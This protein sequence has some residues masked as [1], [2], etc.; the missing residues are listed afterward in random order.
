[1]GNIE[2]DSSPKPITDLSIYPRKTEHSRKSANSL[3]DAHIPLAFSHAPH[4]HS[5]IHTPRFLSLHPFF[6]PSDSL[7]NLTVMR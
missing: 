1:M 2:A 7:V 6:P 5:L 4:I 3:I